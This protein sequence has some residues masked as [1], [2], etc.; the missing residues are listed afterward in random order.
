MA[1]Q[2]L[3]SAQ[4]GSLFADSVDA[5][6][7]RSGQ[8]TIP[9]GASTIAVANTAITATSVVVFSPLSAPDATCV[10]IRV[11]LNAGVGFSLTGAANATAVVPFTWFVAKY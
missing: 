3:S 2:L 7:A 5:D 4:V 11:V 10:G 9:I 1:Q 6:M 8:A